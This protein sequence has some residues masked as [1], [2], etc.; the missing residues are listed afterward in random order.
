M[1]SATNIA[2]KEISTNYLTPF[3]VFQK[4]FGRA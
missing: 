2:S 3:L 4:A 1:K